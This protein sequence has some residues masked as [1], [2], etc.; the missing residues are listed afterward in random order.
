M[1]LSGA[2]GATV[3]LALLL[4]SCGGGGSTTQPPAED[5][6]LR[7]VSYDRQDYDADAYEA[8]AGTVR[9][10]LS[11]IGVQEH[12]LL[13]EGL[14]DEMRLVAVDGGTD[15][16]SLELEPGRYTLYCDIAGHRSSGMEARL[17]VN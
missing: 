4:A 13:V 10:E 1:Q 16:G 14:E 9:F 6:V 7:I 3:A 2:I 12:T 17:T 5:G 8:D 15:A 11:Q